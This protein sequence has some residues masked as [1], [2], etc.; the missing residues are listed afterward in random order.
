M[1]FCPLSTGDSSITLVSLIEFFPL[2]PQMDQAQCGTFPVKAIDQSSA[3]FPGFQ[4]MRFSL[5]RSVQRGF[6]VRYND[7]PKRRQPRAAALLPP[8]QKCDHLIPS[9]HQERFK[10]KQTGETPLPP[11]F[12]LFHLPFWS[13]S[14]RLPTKT[15]VTPPSVSK[16][17]PV[18]GT[19]A[20]APSPRRVRR[21]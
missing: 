10:P 9:H 6:Q 21:T 15:S 5:C 16:V 14:Q 2:F 8:S 11:T 7:L 20:A 19:A 1:S 18:L 3:G 17:C 13:F 4:L 12:A